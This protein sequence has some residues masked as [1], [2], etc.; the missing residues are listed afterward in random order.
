MRTTGLTSRTL[1]AL[2]ARRPYPAVT[3]T[4]PTHRREP[5]RPADTVRLRNLIAEAKRRL[6][7]D[8]DVPREARYEI[9]GQL[10]R[11][12]A[13]VDLRHALDS[14]V[15]FAAKG[16]YEVWTLPR[17]APER[18][19]FSDTFLTRNL[20][21]AR[22]RTRPYWVL[23][24]S[25]DRTTLWSG[26]DSTLQE[27]RAA[28]FPLE[29]EPTYNEDAEREERIGNVPGPYDDEGTRT[30]LRQVDTAVD[31][32]LATDPRPLYLVGLAPALSL[33]EEVG[34]AAK[35]AVSK[36][37]K[38]GLTNGPARALADALRPALR[39]QA[40]RHT[41]RVLERIGQAQGRRAFAAGLEEVWQVCKEG[42]IELLD[43]EENHQRTVKVTGEHLTPVD[44]EETSPAE[45]GTAVLEDI[46]DEI[47]ET[48]LDRGGEIAFVPDDSL[49]A[50]ERIAAV[51]R[52]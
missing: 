42:R 7:A 20:V 35:A 10:D 4:L 32:L 38:G 37:L 27:E 1:T 34:S 50:H 23:A 22:E 48:T 19:V 41:G 24:V 17:T 25:V 36:V 43:V 21:A 46:V 5:Y 31:A 2:R 11:A 9:S 28:G 3:I 26:S 6:E 45:L 39:E 30:Y 18:V 47:I 49:A 8:P 44:P 51:L 40:E 12:M 16:E 29:P 15:I 13:D 14:L 33:L 52:F